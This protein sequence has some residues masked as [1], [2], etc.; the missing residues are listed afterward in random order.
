MPHEDNIPKWNDLP[1]EEQLEYCFGFSSISQ[2]DNWF[3]ETER[4]LLKE[5]GAILKLY[6]VDDEHV[7]V[8]DN[9]AVFKYKHAEEIMK[10]DP[11]TLR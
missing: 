3:N 7:L 10:I 8:G 2:L 11:V 1:G 4:S 5:R 9:Q 6:E